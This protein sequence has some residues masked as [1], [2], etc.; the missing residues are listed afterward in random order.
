MCTSGRQHPQPQ[1]TH[2]VRDVRQVLA[3]EGLAD[4]RHLALARED[5]VEQR[6]HGAL[7]L[8]PAPRV[9]DR[10]GEGLPEDRLA[11]V[12]RDEEGDGRAD[13]VAL[14]EHL[15]EQEDHEARRAELEDDKHGGGQTDLVDGAVPG[16]EVYGWRHG[17]RQGWRHGWRHGCR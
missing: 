15:V 12:G 8:R 10:R 7:E 1:P 9:D 17:W 14:V 13:A 2:Q 4:R 3:E 5:E 11:D 6:E 16:G